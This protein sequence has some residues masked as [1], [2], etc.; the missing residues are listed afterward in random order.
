MVRVVVLMVVAMRAIL[1][2]RDAVVAG[3]HADA[4]NNGARCLD[5]YGQGKR[6]NH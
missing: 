1:S 6:E 5:R 3:H 4:R 2:R